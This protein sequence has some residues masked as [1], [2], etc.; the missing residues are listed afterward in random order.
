MRTLVW[1]RGKDLRVADHVPL[2]SAV[3]AGEVVPVFVLDPYFFAPA[4]AQRM[5]NRIAFLLE[6]GLPV[7][8]HLRLG[9]VGVGVGMGMGMGMRMRHWP[10]V[11][12]GRWPRWHTRAHASL[13]GG[14]LSLE[15]DPAENAATWRCR[16]AQTRVARHMLFRL[17]MSA[18]RRR[19]RV[20]GFRAPVV[21]TLALGSIGT[22]C[23]GELTAELVR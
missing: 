8:G 6:R 19:S 20:S 21:V 2:Q 13:T 18:S 15:A 12:S 4:R 9:R 7:A 1:F 11:V 23:G 16:S 22:A 14:M 5:P 10:L 17:S 3:K